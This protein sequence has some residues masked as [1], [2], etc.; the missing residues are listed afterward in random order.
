MNPLW[1]TKL[2]RIRKYFWRLALNGLVYIALFRI[3]QIILTLISLQDADFFFEK[4]SYDSEKDAAC[5]I[6]FK[7]M[8]YSPV[9]VSFYSLE[10][11]ACYE[12]NGKMHDIA[13]MSFGHIKF[14]KYEPLKFDSTVKVNYIDI[15]KMPGLLRRN[16]RVFIE[17]SMIVKMRFLIIPLTFSI[18]KKLI[19]I[20]QYQQQNQEKKPSNGNREKGGAFIINPFTMISPDE[21]PTISPFK[22]FIIEEIVLGNHLYTRIFL[23]ILPLYQITLFQN[24]NVKFSNI[25][26][27]LTKPMEMDFIVDEA[28]A[29]T[30]EHK[31]ALLI[32]KMPGTNPILEILKDYWGKGFVDIEVDH[33][34]QMKEGN[35]VDIYR[36]TDK[37]NLINLRLPFSNEKSPILNGNWKIDDFCIDRNKISCKLFVRYSELVLVR[38]W[39]LYH[40]LRTCIPEV[41]LYHNDSYLCSIRVTL[42]N[43]AE[44]IKIV[45]SPSEAGQIVQPMDNIQAA[46]V[47]ISFNTSSRLLMY[48]DQPLGKFTL[49]FT[50]HCDSI[51]WM[52]DLELQFTNNEMPNKLTYKGTEIKMQSDSM[53][54]N[55]FEMISLALMHRLQ[56]PVEHEILRVATTLAKGEIIQ[57]GKFRKVFNFPETSLVLSSTEGAIRL[58]IL[59]DGYIGTN[60]DRKTEMAVTYNIKTDLR[61]ELYAKFKQFNFQI[62][63]NICASG[64]MLTINDQISIPFKI[65]FPFKKNGLDPFRVCPCVS[66]RYQGHES[67]TQHTFSITQ[68]RDFYKS[69]DIKYLQQYSQYLISNKIYIPDL[70]LEH[71]FFKCWILA[72]TNGF[73][74]E[75]DIYQKG[76]VIKPLEEIFLNLKVILGQ[77]TPAEFENSTTRKLVSFLRLA[78]RVTFLN[79]KVHGYL[80]PSITD[81]T[82][83]TEIRHKEKDGAMDMCFSLE[84]PQNA[85]YWPDHME[86]THLFKEIELKICSDECK[87]EAPLLI[88]FKRSMTSTH[89]KF[90]LSIC[91]NFA[92]KS[93]YSIG[94]RIDDTNFEAIKTNPETIK[95]FCKDL[96]AYCKEKLLKKSEHEPYSAVDLDEM[97]HIEP[98]VIDVQDGKILTLRFNIYAEMLN[99]QIVDTAKNI[100]SKLPLNQCPLILE[101]NVDIQNMPVV[102]IHGNTTVNPIVYLEMI[103]ANE[104]F[105]VLKKMRYQLLEYEP[106]LDTTRA[107]DLMLQKLYNGNQREIGIFKKGFPKKKVKE[108][109]F[110]NPIQIG[111]K[112]DLTTLTNTDI[113]DNVLLY[114]EDTNFARI[115]QIFCP[116]IELSKSSGPF[117]SALARIFREGIKVLRA[118]PVPELYFTKPVCILI[119]PDNIGAFLS[120]YTSFINFITEPLSVFIVIKTGLAFHIRFFGAQIDEN[121][122]KN[123]FKTV[124]PFKLYHDKRLLRGSP[125][126]FK[127]FILFKNKIQKISMRIPEFFESKYFVGIAIDE[128][129]FIRTFLNYLFSFNEQVTIYEADTFTILRGVNKE[130][131]KCIK[132]DQ[133]IA[134]NEEEMVANTAL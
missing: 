129:S 3:Y 107:T 34:Y 30:K 112:I 41:H 102:L 91:G 86:I 79:P 127:I 47:E 123:M 51:R 74:F 72:D 10:T 50:G 109:T 14:N 113:P 32:P 80:P 133:R 97:L 28:L 101:I 46:E 121:L 93:L 36:K 37:F 16:T 2:K 42:L 117:F 9:Q 58:K 39:I 52:D 56:I 4:L 100:L 22:S 57:N 61:V 59:P 63:E 78:D 119:G 131:Y 116:S 23:D 111:I 73:E 62:W 115:C 76:L 44:N 120:R 5:S 125:F 90:E 82:I 98:V 65:E 53:E 48:S 110:E 122:N 128:K 75:L 94:L 45:Q 60:F 81:E 15:S 24:A 95:D 7:S 27:R 104:S 11:K 43:P 105:I 70:A 83:Y 33:I 96:I 108:K 68:K 13:Q 69:N 31:L 114:L 71:E 132:I 87:Y 19:E 12:L 21:L 29:S 64:V 18:R 54:D 84:F 26:F 118:L 25:H 126:E 49:R 17:V 8:G 130:I 66:I 38:N 77:H 55:H 20:N 89:Y 106:T 40:L 124:F 92:R 103:I 35:P 6:T 99:R 88:L 67:P 134:T 1:K 85:L